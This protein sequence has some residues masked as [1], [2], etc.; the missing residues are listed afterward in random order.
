MIGRT[1]LHYRILDRLGRGGMG[2]VYAAFDSRL[3]RRVALKI[4]PP[5]VAGDPERQ[6]RFER[7]AR[8]IAALNH[9]NIV[10]VYSV[11]NTEGTRFITMELVEGE[12]LAELIPKA[13]LPLESFLSLAIPL[14]D[15]LSSAHEQGITHR[16]L[17]PTNVMVTSEG[18]VKVLDFGL[19]K[20]HHQAADP[21]L[22]EL[23][24]QSMTQAGRIL[25]TV[26]Y[27]SPEQAE[28]KAVDRRADVFT[29][30]IV[31]YEMLTGRHPFRG[32]S[33]AATLSAILKDTPRSVTELNPNLPRELG[34]TVKR[35]LSKDPGRRY[36]S[37]LDLRNELQDMQEELG[38]SSGAGFS[39]AAP[40]APSGKGMG[41]RLVASL[42]GALLLAGGLLLAAS[43]LRRAPAKREVMRFTIGPPDGGT[44][45]ALPGDPAPAV[46]PDGRHV[47]FHASA[48]DPGGDLWVRSLDSLS[49][50]V[51]PGT[52]GGGGPFWSPDGKHIGFSAEGKLK[53]ID[54]SGGPPEVLC[55]GAGGGAWNREGVVL[56]ARGDGL[57]RVSSQGGQATRVSTL[58]VSRRELSHG[59]P[60]FLPDGRHFLFLVNAEEPE[61]RG[62]Y[63]G[64][65]D[66][67]EKKRILSETSEAAY[68]PPGYLLFVRSNTLLAQAFDPTLLQAIGDPVSIAD[69]VVPAPSSRFAPFSVSAD[70]VAYRQGGWSFTT[71]FVWV[72][73]KGRELGSVGVAGVNVDPSLSPDETRLAFTRFDPG[74]NMDIWTIDLARNVSERLT[75]DAAFE[76]EPVWSPDGQTIVFASSRRGAFDQYLKTANGADVE[77]PLP[78]SP[79]PGFSHDWSSDGRFV[80]IGSQNDVWV[81]PVAGDRRPYRFSETKFRKGQPRLSPDRRWLAFTSD[82]T[83]TPEIYVMEFREAGRR[84]RVSTHGGLDPRWRRDGRE[85]FYLEPGAHT[86]TSQV[87]EATLMATAVGSGSTFEGGP[88]QALFR[89]R[90]PA[91]FMTSFWTYAVASQGQRFLIDKVIAVEPSLIT[92][93]VNWKEAFFP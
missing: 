62:V 46:S 72:D 67:G 10:T 2:E 90:V 41:F 93:V 50:R 30:G 45:G 11:E 88:P 80:L 18:L 52:R 74:T 5:E 8:A 51:L 9:P 84:W 12:T 4:L 87:A 29:L 68:A 36:Q 19:A 61:H 39:A 20:I 64:S 32:P 71:Q 26:S 77:H 82:E 44:F 24:T 69:R 56:F 31:F 91:L 65:L 38:A 3:S 57:Y 43:A 42:A 13:G 73:R 58:D 66:S 27:M 23:A 14:A 1:L 6:R 89:V 78:G 85:L 21:M 15:A 37:C 22:S 60:Q 75:A 17:K 54:L 70:I 48:G 28:G 92:V 35:C 55:D 86:G 7:E 59:F 81:A 25:G 34:K 47:A 83:G 49:A 16:D 76:F 33:S 63:A 79:P 53:K 40:P